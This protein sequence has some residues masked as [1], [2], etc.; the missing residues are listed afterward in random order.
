MTCRIT[1][2]TSLQISQEFN[3]A[4]LAPRDTE[5]KQKFK[6]LNRFKCAKNWS[7]M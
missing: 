1:S 2:G 6:G 7:E 4:F 5:V 3:I